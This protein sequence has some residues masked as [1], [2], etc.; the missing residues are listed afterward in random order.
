VDKYI[1]GADTETLNGYPMTMQFYSEDIACEDIFFVSPDNAAN[2]FL[3][4]CATRRRNTQ[5]VVYVHNLAFDLVEFLWG[6][7]RHLV[8][9]SGD[10]DFR[11]GKLSVRGVYGSP[12]FCHVSNGHDVTV[13]IVDSYSYFRGSLAKG[14][15]LFCPDLPKLKRV[16]GIGAKRFTKRDVSF[17]EY[18]MRDAVIAY[19]M[20][21]AIERM[22]QEYEIK[23]CVSVAHMAATIFKHKFLTYTI[24]QPTREIIDAALLSYHGGK[25]NIT[26][27]AG[28][29]DNITSL[30]ISS[31]YPHA[32]RELPAFADER[33]YK[34]F[35][36]SRIRRVPPHGVYCVTGRV[37]DCPWPSLFSHGFKP[38]YGAIDR[39]WIQGH[40]L[41]EALRSKEFHPTKVKGFFYDAERDHQAPALRSFVET[42]YALK[43]REKDPVLRYMQKLI[44]NSVSG[45][46]IQTR[47]RNSSAYTDIDAG[48]TTTASELVAGGM[49]HPFIASDITAHTRARI[50]ELEHKYEAIHTATDGILF[51]GRGRSVGTGIG[52]LT[53][54]ARDATLLLVRNKCYVLYAKKDKKTQPSKVF[55]GKHIKKFALHGFQGTVTDLE[56][57]IAT[58]RRK[59]NVNR[60]NRLKESLKRGLTPNEF[61][62]REYTLKVPP[63]KVR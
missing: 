28:W 34:R 5:H 54:E 33:L 6:H 25:N 8:G 18:A 62:R 22:H 38:L 40:E 63:L 49:F 21:K 19:H 14:A 26:V 37:D 16:D 61:V 29:Y 9:P 60:P 24:P 51:R 46:F 27:D 43:E 32:M 11:V 58:N 30:D 7:H 1:Y 35:R 12:T 59:Y 39:V 23:Q 42:F 41:N 10:F 20:G 57:L 50:H 44:L 17:T 15:E 45:K 2:T 13:T 4:W 55:R 36:G 48:V 47:K 52:A 56:R 31:A 3:K 53:L